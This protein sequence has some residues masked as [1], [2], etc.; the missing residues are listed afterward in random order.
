MFLGAVTTGA[1]ATTPPTRGH[2][3]RHRALPRQPERETDDPGA[4][5]LRQVATITG[6]DKADT[7][8]HPAATHLGSAAATPS[9]SW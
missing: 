3:D 7:L 9:G 8:T 6:T 2:D 1:A 5:L 4:D